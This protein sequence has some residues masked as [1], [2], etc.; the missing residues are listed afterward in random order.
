MFPSGSS[1]C[2]MFHGSGSYCMEPVSFRIFPLVP[3]YQLLMFSLFFSTFPYSFAI[4]IILQCSL[5]AEISSL[6]LHIHLAKHQSKAF[7]SQSWDYVTS[8]HPFKGL[9]TR[10][11]IKIQNVQMGK[12]WITTLHTCHNIYLRQK[13]RKQN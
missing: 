5:I 2:L 12:V 9:Y 11:H 4:L 1:A 6:K 10:E 3:F 7:F 13:F 8:Q